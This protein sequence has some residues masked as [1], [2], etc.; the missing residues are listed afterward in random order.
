M[1]IKSQDTQ[2]GSLMFKFLKRLMDIILSL[3]FI[4]V[5]F[6]VYIATAIAVYLQDYHNPIYRH[7]RLSRG[8]ITFDTLKFRSMVVNADEIMKKDKNLYQQLRSNNNKAIDDPRITKV[9]KFI[10][11]YSIDEFPQMFNVLFGEMSFVGPRPITEDEYEKYALVSDENKKRIDRILT[12]KPGITGYWQTHG[13]SNIDFDT[14]MKMEYDYATKKSL[15]LDIQI[16]LRTPY[17]ML[18]GDGAY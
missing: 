4:I 8:A 15:I 18:K 7:R 2:Y 16:I 14:R 11:K 17:A 3:G 13:R 5:F 9:G 6:P 1:E 12:V 10:R